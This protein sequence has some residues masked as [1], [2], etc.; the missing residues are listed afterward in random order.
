MTLLY[1]SCAILATIIFLLILWRR[2]VPTNE[3][4]IIQSSKKTVSYGKE[5][6][7]GNTYY[8]YPSWLPIIGITK[9]ILPVS[10]FALDLNDYEAYDK[11]RLPFVVDIKAF[12]RIADSNIAA[13]RVSSFKELQEQLK[14]IVQGAVRT[15]LA[16]NEI[17]EIMQGRSKFGDEFTKEVEAQ[18][19]HWG[20]ST[21]KNIEM[22]DIRD[23]QGSHVI[24]NIMDKKKSHIEMESRI[25]V[26]KNQQEAQ[27]SEIE[28]QKETELRRQQAHQE[29]G[30][31]KA[32][33]NKQIGIAEQKAIQE[34]KEE[35]RLTKDK[36]MAVLRV[37]EVKQAEIEKDKQV[38]QADQQKATAIILA[39]GKKQKDIVEAEGIK[40]QTI[41]KAEANLESQK[42]GA[43]G[44]KAE[45]EAKAKAEELILLAP[46]QAQ[47]TLAKEIGENQSYQSYLIT[48]R[49]IEANQA[50]GIE[51]AKALTSADLKVIANSGSVESGLNKLTDIL[52]SKGGTNIGATLEGL[53]QSDIGKSLINKFLG[54][55]DANKNV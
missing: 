26:A 35:E 33:A 44:I 28:A 14:A 27:I 24:K 4:H 43:E 50:V 36:E 25:E 11:G 30:Q 6:E 32:I 34:I 17:G 52:S 18:L 1:T 2:V 46:I 5:M 3:V 37:Q 8:E 51:Q 38:V 41:L 55:N 16:A 9:S 10:V 39:E 47:I 40:Q 19:Q 13:Q 49:Q 53:S 12:F 29:V 54:N 22:M 42:L 23:H 45:G 7:A 31:R 21:V 48:V 20:V 15:I